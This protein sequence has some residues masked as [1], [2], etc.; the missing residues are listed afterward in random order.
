[1]GTNGSQLENHFWKTFGEKVAPALPNKSFVVWEAD[2]LPIDI[3]SLPPRSIIDP[4][5]SPVR[6]LPRCVGMS[7]LP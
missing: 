1:M 6:T 5:Q 3:D 4:F 2:A 7:E